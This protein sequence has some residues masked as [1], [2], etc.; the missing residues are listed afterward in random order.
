LWVKRNEPEVW[1]RTKKV[2]LLEDW[3]LYK[4]TGKFI[5]EKT[6]QSSTIY[7]DIHNAK[8]WGEMLDFIG[9]SEDMLPKLYSSAVEVGEYEGTRVVTGAIDQIAGAIGAGVV[10]RFLEDG[11]EA[12]ALVDLNLEAAQATAAQLDPTGKRAIAFKCNVAVPADVERCFAEI[13]AAFGRVDILVNNAGIIRDR[14]IIKMPVEDWELVLKIDLK[15]LPQDDEGYITTMSRA[16][17]RIMPS[18]MHPDVL[19]FAAPGL[20]EYGILREVVKVLK[21]WNQHFEEIVAAKA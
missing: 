2:F 18:R 14:T 21:K 13:I 8:W 7:F 6:L 9:V 19:V 11:V 3:I 15:H 12:V 5:S 20:N 1:A 4:M 10:K 16:D 17:K